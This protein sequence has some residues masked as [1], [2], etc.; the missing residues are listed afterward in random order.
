MTSFV[1]S[2]ALT[3]LLAALFIFILLIAA[4]GVALFDTLHGIAV[5]DYIV[6]L[7]EGGLLSSATILGVHLGGVQTLNAQGGV[8]PTQQEPTAS[9]VTATPP[10][11]QPA[12]ATPAWL[13]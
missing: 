11:Q 6:G 3:K 9:P 2:S 13:K 1:N 5:S 4:L 7:L 10:A 12:P 8:Q